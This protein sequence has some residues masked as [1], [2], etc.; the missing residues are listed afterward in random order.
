MINVKC[1]FPRNWHRQSP[2]TELNLFRIVQEALNNVEKHSRARNLWIRLAIQDH[3]VVLKIR[4]D[5][6]GF[7]Q[8]NPKSNGGKRRGIGLTN[9]RERASSV[10]GTCEV[11]SALKQ[12]THIIVRAPYLLSQ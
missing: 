7:D 5:G 4:D 3:T 8:K 1:L 11:M 12:G 9:I 10:G 6:R 2:A